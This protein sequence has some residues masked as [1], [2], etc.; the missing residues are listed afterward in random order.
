MLSA[1]RLQPLSVLTL[2]LISLFFSLDVSTRA[3][4]AETVPPIVQEIKSGQVASNHQALNTIY[5]ARQYKPVW[6]KEDEQSKDTL[7]A[8]YTRLQEIWNEHGLHSPENLEREIEASIA[9]SKPAP[10][11]HLDTMLTDYALELAQALNGE[12]IPLSLLYVGWDFH[13]SSRN[14]PNELSQAIESNTV[15]AFVNTL[16]P[17]NFDYPLYMNAL[18][19]YREIQNNGGWTKIAT[20]Q[21]IKPGMTDPRLKDVQKRLIAEKYLPHDEN[22]TEPELYTDSLK[23]AVIAYQ[24]RNGL[25]PDGNLGQKTISTM[26]IS[27][28]TRIDQIRANMSRIRLMPRELPEKL[29]IVNIANTT[30]K[31]LDKGNVIFE[32]PVVTGRPDRKTPYIQSY[33]RSVIFNPSWHVPA[34]IA[35]EDILPKLRKDPLYLEKQ[36]I[37]IKGSNDNDVH[38]TMIDWKNV[39]PSS[40]TYQLRQEPGNLNALGRIKFDFDN[41]FSVY[42]HGTPHEELFAKASRHLSSGCVRLQDPVSYASVVLAT[43]DGG[44]TKQKIQ[45]SIDQSKTRWLQVSEQMPVYFIYQTAYFPTA[46]APV[47]FAPDDYNYDRILLD[48]QVAKP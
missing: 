20:G 11:S 3:F 36:G 33:I 13:K 16:A 22:T 28:G 24:K 45:D 48:A 26:N 17:N 38:G 19:E 2:S 37:V 18:K 29:T 23:A 46:D 10:F 7:N 12:D 4:S 5:A 27:V 40:F 32:S 41:D 47:S 1:S 14:I 42:M 44:W 21:T 34:K 43:N 9:D 35:R 8:T 15:E 39:S 25:E 31:V 6:I 30:I